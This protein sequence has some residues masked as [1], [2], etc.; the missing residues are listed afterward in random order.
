M[1]SCRQT[2]SAPL[3]T[4]AVGDA[5]SNLPEICNRHKREEMAN[6]GEPSH[7]QWLVSPWFGYWLCVKCPVLL[8]VNT[9][10]WF[11][12]ILI[13][14]R[15]ANWCQLV[16]RD[17]ICKDMVPLIEV[18]ITRIP[19][20][21]GSDW[22]DLPNIVVRLSDGTFTKKQSVAL[23]TVGALIHCFVIM[24]CRNCS[25]CHFQHWTYSCVFLLLWIIQSLFSLPSKKNVKGLK[26]FFK[27][28][29]HFFLINMKSQPPGTHKLMQMSPIFYSNGF[30]SCRT[31][32][33]ELTFTDLFVWN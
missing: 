23:S 11:Y 33:R 6:G 29:L 1:P 13:K 16:L 7:F 10:A 19:T 12:V 9:S 3:P 2:M 5:M 15:G 31:V 25:H 14:N 32:V 20:A 30:H 8:F 28:R 22:C 26:S 27:Y 4:V 24:P 17:H 18:R 21:S